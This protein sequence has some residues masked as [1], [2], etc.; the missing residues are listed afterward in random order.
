ML[1]SVCKPLILGDYQA[2]F[3]VVTTLFR[4]IITLQ[5]SK[6][7]PEGKLWFAPSPAICLTLCNTLD[8]M[9]RT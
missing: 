4:G 7:A 9:G 2:I 6:N 3:C 5:K 8:H 1:F